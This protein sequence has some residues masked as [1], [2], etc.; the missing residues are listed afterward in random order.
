MDGI[1]PVIAGAFCRYFA[2][3]RHARELDSLLRELTI[4]KEF[5]GGGEQPL[6]GKTFVI[7]GKVEH[8]ANRKELKERIEGLGGKVTGSVTNRT[9]Y[10]INNDRASSSSKNKRAQELGIPIISEEEFLELAA[11]EE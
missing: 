5:A 11:G 10:L 2:D 6:A 8:F 4:E 3:E 7:T 1:G 9:D